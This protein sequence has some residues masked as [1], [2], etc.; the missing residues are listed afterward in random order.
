M[1]TLEEIENG[2]ST[3]TTDGGLAASTFR[4]ILTVLSF[5]ESIYGQLDLTLQSLETLLPIA[6]SF[7][8]KY[9]SVW[10]RWASTIQQIRGILKNQ[11]PEIA[12]QK[13]RKPTNPW[14][15]KMGKYPLLACLCTSVE[16]SAHSGLTPAKAILLIRAYGCTQNDG[17]FSAKYPDFEKFLADSIRKSCSCQADLY[18]K[19]IPPWNGSDNAGW[20]E[21]FLMSTRNYR[22]VSVMSPFPMR[23]NYQAI[24]ALKI[25]LEL[26]SRKNDID[27]NGTPHHPAPRPHSLETPLK[28]QN[29]SVVFQ[30][31]DAHEKVLKST[32]RA[33]RTSFNYIYNQP[34][35]A[36]SD[37]EG[38]AP[39]SV[40]VIPQADTHS[41]QPT[42]PSSVQSLD[43][44][45]TNYRTAMDNQHLPWNWD[46]LNHFEVTALNSALRE[47]SEKVEAPPAEK[48][49]AFIIWLL[50]A[51][52]QTI[53]EILNFDLG[54]K[55][56][57]RS[58]IVTG[59]IY[60]RNVISPPHSFIPKS[61]QQSN[62]QGHSPSISLALPAPLPT[63]VSELGLVASNITPIK[64]NSTIGACLNLDSERAG[65][66]VR[67]FLDN[68]RTRSFRLL[69]GR[70][71]KVLSKEIMRVTNDPVATHIL[72]S[73]PTDMPPAG[74]YYTSYSKEQLE[75]IYSEAV[76]RV[77][78]GDA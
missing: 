73:L 50:L 47:S 64:S 66:A 7:D 40:Y 18:W 45:Y 44:R 34:T 46:C 21:S 48:Q 28:E 11:I 53:E 35:A 5:D 75:N 38:L 42:P 76:A 6:E 58:A 12:A 32:N 14:H 33:K 62:L 23:T 8:H 37:A 55:Q 1:V 10:P 72:S 71:R 30:P 68:H 54:V 36:A 69:P 65:Q 3:N 52:G 57:N 2:L 15:G 13:S 49:G 9:T 20:R 78:G 27:T 74:V 63:L 16:S 22:S 77:L 70:I 31:P 60:I 29:Q 59:P 41:D 19:L 4:E 39:E 67:S 43:V 51:T 25:T 24:H 56:S 61:G 17:T 26:V